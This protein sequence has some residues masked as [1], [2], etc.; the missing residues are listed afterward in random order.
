MNWLPRYAPELNP[1]E[2][3]WRDLKRHPLAHRTFR[4][5]DDLDPA[6][7]QPIATLNKERTGWHPCHTLPNAA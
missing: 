2:A 6:I 4:G 7:P 1:I 5:T 3:T